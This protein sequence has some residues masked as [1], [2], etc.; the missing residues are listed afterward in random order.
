MS[1]NQVIRCAWL[2]VVALG[3]L[4]ATLFA[5]HG[6]VQAGYG[7]DVRRFSGQETDAV[8][9][10]NAGTVTLGGAGFLTP[11][12]SGGIE[13]EL[14]AT[15][16]VRQSV[17]LTVAGRP[18]TITT[19]YTSRRR[20]V[21]ALAGFHSDAG[22]PVRVGLYG[23]LTFLA[24]RRVTSSDAPPIV[25]TDPQPPTVFTDRAVAPVMQVD[26][27]IR[28]GR[29]LAAVGTVRARG[30]ELTSE[31]RGFSVQPGIAVRASF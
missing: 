27:A 1:A 16:E 26:I 18:D 19:T 30:L 6:F 14:G 5:Q 23:G 29:Y 13:V 11:A 4:P 22:R 12:V 15:S 31:L 28:L 7:V 21:S 3:A 2:L 9:D 10:A 17:T 20:S 24:F 8:F 25:L